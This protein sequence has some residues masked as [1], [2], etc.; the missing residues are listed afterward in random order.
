M[1][2]DSERV[3]G[4]NRRLFAGAP[5]HHHI[6]RTLLGCPSVDEVVIDTDSD[7]IMRECARVFPEVRLIKRP[8]SLRGGHVP[9][10]DVL[11]H[12][13]M[14]VEAEF[15]L[16]THATN[17]LLTGAT[18][19]RAIKDFLIARPDCDSLVSVTRLQSRLYDASGRPINHDPRRLERTQDL[20]PVFEENSNIY[21]FTRDT[22]FE[23][24][25]RIGRSPLFF[26][27]NRIEAMDID[28]E[29]DFRM[30]EA[31]YLAREADTERNE[32]LIR[33][34]AV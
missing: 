30:A 14:Q 17:P 1:R 34:G 21:I 23:H 4:K 6:V 2:H 13:V 5:L 31:L 20:A 33:E 11:K 8:D 19:E 32:A 18:I 16:Q 29:Q 3:P 25:V 9:M 26:E 7:E 27:V 24:G 12:D 22:L 15:Y 10:H 28:D